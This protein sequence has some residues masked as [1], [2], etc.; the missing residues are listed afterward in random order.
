MS[1]WHRG[2]SRGSAHNASTSINMNKE[3]KTK[4]TL[5]SYLVFIRNHFNINKSTN[6]LWKENFGPCTCVFI[7][8]PFVQKLDRA[9]CRINLYSVDNA[10]GFPNTY[11][12]DS[13]LWIALSNF[14]VTGARYFHV[15]IHSDKTCTCAYVAS[16]NNAFEL[17]CIY[18]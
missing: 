18:K 1:W 12:L 15:G 14:W 4:F 10:I 6:S 2:P 13:D 17:N 7:Q 11:P 8:A 16:K 5:S 9:I 3:E